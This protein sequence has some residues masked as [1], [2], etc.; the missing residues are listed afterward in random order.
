MR[1]KPDASS[2]PALAGFV[3]ALC[4]T[5]SSPSVRA[6]GFQLQEQGAAGLGVAYAG[7][8]AAVHDAST[9]F[10]NP[11]GQSLLR[12]RQAVVAMAWIDP[13]TRFR[14]SGASSFSSLGSGGQAGSAKWVPSVFASWSPDPRWSVGLVANAP[15]GLSTRWNP[16]WAG[17]FHGTESAITSRNLGASLAWRSNPVLSFGVGVSYQALDATL[18]QRVMLSPLLPLNSAANGR[19]E[20]S[21]WAWG[22]TLGVLADF[23]SGTRLGVSY[24]S[25]M[26][27]RLT[28]RLTVSETPVPIAQRDITSRISLPDVFS[29]ALAQEL[30]P[31]TRLLADW[32]WTGWHRLREL[33]LLDKALDVP[34]VE[35]ALAMRSSWRVGLGLEHALDPTWLLRAGLA[36]DR[37]PVP[38]AYRT[39]RLPDGHR[40]WLAMGVRYLPSP[41]SRW[42]VDA[43]YAYIRVADAASR[44]PHEG[45]S[46][47]ETARGALLGTYE[48]H[49]NVLAVQA[50]FRF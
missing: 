30:N 31:S 8:A 15:F 39:P 3:L 19:S 50:G 32:S 23:P 13:V 12:N 16:A 27:Y 37:S 20:G 36:Y 49:V 43:G 26:D 17:Q 6:A 10:W 11:A 5:I 48:A 2:G 21:D 18:A 22:Y 45:A 41:S 29:V 42:W 46:A 34:V 40:L 1:L 38:D 4:A 28:G 35:T 47:A 25:R 33:Q 14:D 9:S 44:L 7:Q 24:R